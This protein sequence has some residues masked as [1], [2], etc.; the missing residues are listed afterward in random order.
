ML[1]VATDQDA[2]GRVLLPEHQRRKRNQQFLRRGSFHTPQRNLR[3]VLRSL[4]KLVPDQVFSA[5]AQAAGYKYLEE[6]DR[7]SRNLIFDPSVSDSISG[8]EPRKVHGKK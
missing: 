3:S 1:F 6:S 2:P 7:S 4:E 8:Y 5:A